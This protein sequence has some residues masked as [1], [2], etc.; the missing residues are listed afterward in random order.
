MLYTLS[1][2]LALYPYHSIVYLLPMTRV[3]Y[4][5]SLSLYPYH[6]IVYLLPMTHVVYSLYSLASLSFH[7]IP[8]PYD[9]CCILSLLSRFPIITMVYILPMTHVVYSL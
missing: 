1:L 7:C 4:S 8:P 9:P 5:L 3:V 6:S 2:S